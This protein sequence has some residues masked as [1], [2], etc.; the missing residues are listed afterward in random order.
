MNDRGAQPKRCHTGVVRPHEDGGTLFY[1]AHGRA[2]VIE[3]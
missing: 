2:T 1:G 3:G